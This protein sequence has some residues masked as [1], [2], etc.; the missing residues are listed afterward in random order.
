M[1]QQM[2]LVFIFLTYNILHMHGCPQ[3]N[4]NSLENEI[5][6]VVES[7]CRIVKITS[8]YHFVCLVCAEV[9]ALTRGLVACPGYTPSSFVPYVTV[10][11]NCSGFSFPISQ[12]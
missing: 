1:I 2:V 8:I 3:H 11:S 5:T 7:K 4:H 6:L 9:L 10:R 12:H